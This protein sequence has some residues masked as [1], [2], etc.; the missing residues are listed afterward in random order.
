MTW[1]C[2]FFPDGSYAQSHKILEGLI[3]DYPKTGY[4][5]AALY[6]L[7][8]AM[9]AQ[10][11][12]TDAVEVQ[13]RLIAS[14]PQDARIPEAKLSLAAGTCEPRQEKGSHR[15]AQGRAEGLSGYGSG[16]ACR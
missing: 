6:W 5:P 15:S 16:K 4:M 11:Q 13:K 10:G 9:F 3:D 8:N 14:F 7:G 2:S 12:F 1:R